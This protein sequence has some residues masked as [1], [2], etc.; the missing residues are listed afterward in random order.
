M[1]EKARR[2]EKRTRARATKKR[3][4][5]TTRHETHTQKT[6]RRR[7]FPA[8]PGER[9]RSVYPISAFPP[10]RVLIRDTVCSSP[11]KTSRIPYQ[12][13]RRLGA[14]F[15]IQCSSPNKTSFY[16]AR[17]CS[18]A[19]S[20]EDFPK[21]RSSARR[22]TARRKYIPREKTNKRQNKKPSVSADSQLVPKPVLMRPKQA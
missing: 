13:S 22:T 19:Q 18:K 3:R 5:D 15:G 10:P 17:V 14:L 2:G 21:E 20:K 1:K 9:R 4:H 6:T 7:G 11:T 16:P 8:R 12:T